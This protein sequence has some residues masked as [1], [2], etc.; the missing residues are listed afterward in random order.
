M[1]SGTM[2]LP[3]EGDRPATK[4]KAQKRLNL[5]GKESNDAR[6]GSYL[7]T[8]NSIKEYM[9]RSVTGVSHMAA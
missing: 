5:Q 3:D 7:E 6:M 9:P 8:W 2:V 4:P 1:V